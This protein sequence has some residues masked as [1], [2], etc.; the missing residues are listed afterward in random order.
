ML[1]QIEISDARDGIEKFQEFLE[2]NMLI[3]I[4]ADLERIIRGN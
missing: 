3:I 4:L 2:S 1:V